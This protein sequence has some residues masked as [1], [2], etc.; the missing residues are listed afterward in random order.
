MSQAKVFD[1][2]AHNTCSHYVPEAFRRGETLEE[3]Q[4]RLVDPESSSSRGS[5]WAG[6]VIDL[7][8]YC[9]G[10]I[11]ATTA[12]VTA[13]AIAQVDKPLHL[14]IGERLAHVRVDP[15]ASEPKHSAER[16]LHSLGVQIVEDEK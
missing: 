8:V 1:Q 13:L 11:L 7:A 10:S 2:E 4:E 16:I 15:H 6:N 3:L 14:G 5:N 9:G 12:G